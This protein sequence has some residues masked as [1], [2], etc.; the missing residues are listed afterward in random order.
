MIT[1]ISARAKLLSTARNLKSELGGRFQ[2]LRL[3]RLGIGMSEYQ[4]VALEHRCSALLHQHVALNRVSRQFAQ[5]HVHPQDEICRSD[6]NGR[7]HRAPQRHW[8]SEQPVS[9]G[10]RTAVHQGSARPADDCS[11]H[12]AHKPA[13]GS[14]NFAPAGIV[15]AANLDTQHGGDYVVRLSRLHTN[16]GWPA[17]RKPASQ[18]WKAQSM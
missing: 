1:T 13:G 15:M 18:H 5:T 10:P 2:L 4:L 6:G 17:C 16:P 7:C 8:C 12:P 9:C 14:H 3:T 11:H